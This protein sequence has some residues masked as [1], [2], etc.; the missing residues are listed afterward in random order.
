M[1]GTCTIDDCESIACGRGLCSK[2]WQAAKKA[3]TL[4]AEW[5]REQKKARPM[6][7]KLE[8][9]R[10]IDLDTG[11]WNWAGQTKNGYGQVP[12]NIGSKYVRAHR[13]AYEVWIG[14]IPEGME[15]DHLCRNRKCFNPAHLEAVTHKENV[16]RGALSQMMKDKASAQT[17]CYKGHPLFGE[18][19]VLVG[20]D[21]KFRLCRTCRATRQ[22]DR[23]HANKDE[24]NIQRKRN[25]AMKTFKNRAAQGDLL[26]RRINKLPEGITPAKTENGGFVVAHSETGA[27]HVIDARPNVKVYDTEDPLLSYLE[28]IDATDKME[29][30]LRHLRGHDTHETISIPPGIYELRRQREYSPEGWKRASD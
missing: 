16:R 2:H 27:H 22:R 20:P 11:C 23:Y 28:V 10:L 21:K 17:H 14:E 5:T 9:N 13:A 18:N 12:A 19:L 6:R 3:G 26:I 30:L 8:S 15:L 29:T 1:R 7:E 24:I 4:P 25:Y